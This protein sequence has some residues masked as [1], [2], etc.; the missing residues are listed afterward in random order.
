M[1][2]DFEQA[3]AREAV[4]LHD[5][6]RDWLTGALPRTPAAFGRFR[7]AMGD[8]LLVISPR[9]T[10]SAR[11]DILA[12]FEGLHGQL[13]DKAG[14]FEITVKNV[15]CLR[16][17]GD[18]L[19]CTYEEWHRLEGE[20]SARLTTVLYGRN[21]DAPLGVEWL[22]VHETWLP[23]QAPAAGERFPEKD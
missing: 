23:G 7:A 9:G 17:L 1:D 3:C 22:H 15:Q 20:S 10:V 5:F 18:A 19:L 13:A 6:F 2:H 4:E 8:G 12:E 14:R 21:P 11:D 16:S